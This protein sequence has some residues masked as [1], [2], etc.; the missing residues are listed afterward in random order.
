MRQHISS[1]RR[2]SLNGFSIT[3]VLVSSLIIGT[4]SAIAAPNFLESLENSKQKEAQATVAQVQTIIMAY[5]D[6]TNETPKTWKNLNSITAIMKVNAGD[7]ASQS[8]ANDFAA[9]TLPGRNYTLQVTAPSTGETVY[10]IIANPIALNSN[11]DIRACLDI[12]NGASDLRSG[13]SN[14]PAESPQCS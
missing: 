2:E 10:E 1:T 11:L 9:I 8:K 14:S 5:I 13:S 6:E 7:E 12:S 3:E 4:L